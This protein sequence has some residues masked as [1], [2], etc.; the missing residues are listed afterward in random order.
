[1]S[2]PDNPLQEAVERRVSEAYTKGYGDGMR[3]VEAYAERLHDAAMLCILR[4]RQG[5]DTLPEPYKYLAP[6]KELTALGEVLATRHA[7]L[8]KT[9]N[10]A[11]QVSAEASSP[12]GCE[13]TAEASGPVG[14][15][16]Q[17]TICGTALAMS[18]PQAAPVEPLTERDPCGSTFDH[19]CDREDCQRAL[20]CMRTRPVVAARVGPR[21]LPKITGCRSCDRKEWMCDE[22]EDWF[23]AY[24]EGE[25]AP[26]IDKS[27]L[28]EAFFIGN[29]AEPPEQYA[30][31]NTA[32]EENKHD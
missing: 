32:P 20:E 15:G 11:G 31:D 23:T 25:S 30:P 29:C 27:D 4:V 18:L 1:M 21:F 5:L 9:P 19:N 24:Y 22:F 12:S 26:K 28:M 10:P 2:L 17:P 7:A 8:A 14:L 16:P 6:W 3:A 13:V